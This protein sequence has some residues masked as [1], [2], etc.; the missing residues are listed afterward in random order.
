MEHPNDGIK[1]YCVLSEGE[2]V[3]VLNDGR[4]NFLGFP[5]RAPFSLD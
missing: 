4:E 3:E 5:D 1:A 2:I